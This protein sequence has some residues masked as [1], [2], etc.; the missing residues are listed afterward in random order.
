M[1]K[2]RFLVC[3]IAIV[4]LGLPA[5][6]AQ[7]PI[8]VPAPPAL[9]A[10]SFILMDFHSGRV[11]ADKQPDARME[12]ASLTKMMTA[13]VVFNEL[14][15]GN[16]SLQDEVTISEKAWRAPGSRMFIEVGDKVSVENLLMGLII[17]SGNDASIALAEH[18]AGTEATFAQV[19]NQYA[20]A[21]GMD[22][23]NFVNATGLPHP[24]HYSSARDIATLSRAVIANFPEY[25]QWY[26]QK[27]FTFNGIR[28]TNRN[29]LLW[30]DP[31]VDGLKTGHT[32]AAGYCLATSAQRDGQRLIAVVMGAKSEKARADHNQ[33]LLN[34]G[35][36]F[37]ATHHLYEAGQAITQPRV[38][39]GETENLPLG[40]EQDLYV[41]I[42]RRQYDNLEA[43]MELPP[44]IT[45]PI[46]QGTVQGTLRVRLDGVVVA[47]QP[48]VALQSVEEAGFFGR[49]KDSVL[50]WFE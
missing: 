44:T 37:F 48:L 11:I 25:Y 10:P 32:D 41:T 31:S 3:L 49:M 4:L 34:Y 26:S 17:Q 5:A 45:A 39:K 33:S 6:H 23:S 46:R 15:A 35:F 21:L 7:Q 42:P 20:V 47:E 36:R 50:L 29:L 43:K 27:E 13:Y 2:P 19:M 12:P 22:G 18:V 9:A 28:Q 14:K 16:I 1:K 30:R 8:P 38:W 40:L 24:D